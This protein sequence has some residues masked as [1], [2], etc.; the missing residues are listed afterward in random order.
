MASISIQESISSVQSAERFFERYIV[1]FGE[2]TKAVMKKTPN[3]VEYELSLYNEK[4]DV[5]II[6]N[7]LTSGYGGHGANATLR[8]LKKCG[9]TVD[10]NFIHNEKNENFELNK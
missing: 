6:D 4:G 10:E 9:F 1:S 8:V 5:I 3:K 2:V 7:Y